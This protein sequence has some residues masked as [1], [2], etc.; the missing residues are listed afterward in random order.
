MWAL[1]LWDIQ[2]R[3]LLLARDRAGIKP[4]Y[5]WQDHR[6]FAFGSEIKS[7]L[8]LGLPRRA[9]HQALYDFLTTGRTDH[10]NTTF[11]EG[12]LP[13]PPAHTMSVDLTTGHSKISRYWSLDLCHQLNSRTDQ[14]YADAFRELFEDAVRIHLI[15][16]RPVGTC[17][18]GGLDSSAL[19]CVINKLIGEDGLPVVG[20]ETRQKTFSARYDD[21]RHDEGR[22]IASVVRQSSI[23]AYTTFPTAANLRES[24]Q[25]LFFHLEEP[26]GSTSIFAQWCVFKLAHEAGIT[27]TLDGQGSDELLAGYFGFFPYYFADL[28]AQR[29]WSR[30]GRD[31][32]AHAALHGASAPHEAKNILSNLL[33]GRLKGALK[34]RLLR[35]PW[36]DPAFLAAPPATTTQDSASGSRLAHA[37]YTSLAVD[38]LPAI[39]RFDDRNSMAHGVESRV[40]FLD[41]RLIEFCFALPPDQ[42]IRKGVTKYILREAMRGIV[43]EEIRHRHDKVRFSTPQ[44]A[45]LRGE[46][47]GW[48]REI[49]DSREFRQ[50]PYFRAGEVSKLLASHAGG[51]ADHE[52]AL[53]RCLAVELWHRAMRV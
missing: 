32:W 37:L 47:L 20:M 25:T 7:L 34:R 6:Q 4:L 33:P 15:S 19:A 39:L 28:L 41:H 26:F 11:F 31:F 21:A 38:P 17:L 27:V 2:R 53:W 22:Y 5:F 13:L 45:W 14:Q 30:L 52:Y 12:I 3:R 9:N 50:R 40:P 44:D 8:A 49:L 35:M 29:Q 42:K 18:S 10:A 48:A 1:A 16:D 43:P 36:L 51:Q 24:W 23:D 46:L